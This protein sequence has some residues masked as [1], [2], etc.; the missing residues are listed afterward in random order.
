MSSPGANGA[1]RRE[2]ALKL[3]PE[4]SDLLNVP[5]EKR[6]EKLISEGDFPEWLRE[7]VI[8][9]QQD[10]PVYGFA[11][12]VKGCM[13][14]LARAA[15]YCA[16]HENEFRAAKKM[17]MSEAE[18]LKTA[19]P[20]PACGNRTAVRAVAVPCSICPDREA[21]G[22]SSLCLTHLNSEN[23]RRKVVEGRGQTFDAEEWR[24]AQA[25]LPRLDDCAVRSCEFSWWSPS[26]R[27]FCPR[28]WRQAKNQFRKLSTGEDFQSF[29]SR[30][31]VA[32]DRDPQGWLDLSG[33]PRL[34]SLEIRHCL[35]LHAKKNQASRWF[36][37]WLR[38]LVT[39]QCHVA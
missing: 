26:H 8:L 4:T 6:F 37:A 23:R 38:S 7:D 34:M 9:F 24:N 11:C 18:W 36:P 20:R 28:H 5:V 21:I 16:G 29:A 22:P 10:D 12:K 2:R 13:Q 19:E 1:D 35:H 3:A 14:S 33:L 15:N 25:P 39:A 31:A 17:G 27:G 32:L 30:F